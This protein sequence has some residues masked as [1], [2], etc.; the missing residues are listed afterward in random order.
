M[1]SLTKYSCETLEFRTVV[2]YDRRFWRG[3][4]TFF[5][6]KNQ[7]T[8]T[9]R[10]IL[11]YKK[12]ADHHFHFSAKRFLEGKKQKLELTFALCRSPVRPPRRSRALPVIKIN[13]FEDWFFEL[14]PSS[15]KK[16]GLDTRWSALFLYDSKTHKTT[17]KIPYSSPMHDKDN[18]LGS[19]SISGLKFQFRD[20]KSGLRRIYF[21]AFPEAYTLRS[22]FSS[23]IRQRGNLLEDFLVAAD[24]ISRVFV[25]PK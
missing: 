20:A 15:L 2:R 16:S 10:G 13:K 18:L 14:L 19:A 8:K 21:E 9:V 24:K 6:K 17:L 12:P 11:L 4:R 1:L 3:I 22:F 25:N 23:R 5:W 7:S